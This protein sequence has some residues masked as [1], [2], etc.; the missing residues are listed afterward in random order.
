MSAGTS[1]RVITSAVPATSVADPPLVDGENRLGSQERGN[2][3]REGGVA[4]HDGRSIH[5]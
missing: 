1:A 4:E 2:V 3:A 5:S